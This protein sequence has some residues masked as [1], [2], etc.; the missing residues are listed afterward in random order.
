VGKVY[1]GKFTMNCK[2]GDDALIIKSINPENMGRM[3]KVVKLV[4]DLDMYQEYDIGDGVVRES[5]VDGIHWYVVPI[6][7]P[8][9]GMGGKSTLHAVIPDAWLQPIRGIETPIA[10]DVETPVEETV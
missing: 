10:H 8:L 7:F 9:V 5:V 2:S 4:G 3:V 6:K 1:K